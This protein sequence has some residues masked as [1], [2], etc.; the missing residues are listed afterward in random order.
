[1]SAVR[2]GDFELMRV[3][4]IERQSMPTAH[5]F[6]DL[7]RQMLQGYLRELGP[8]MIDSDTLELVM[9]FH[10]WVLRRRDTVLLVDCCVGDDK[11]RPTRPKWHRRKSDFLERLAGLGVNPEDV[12]AVMCTHL[13]VDHVGWNT[14]LID[15]RW[16]PTFP[17]ARYIMAEVEYRH[18]RGRADRE[19][20]SLNQ[21][22]FA[23]SVLPVVDSG[24]AELVP[25]NHRI[26]EGVHFEPA[27][28]HTPGTVLVHVEDSGQHGV[29]TGD[30]MHHPFQLDCPGMLS[31]YCEDPA[32]SAKSRMKLCEDYADTSTRILTAHFPNPSSGFIRRDGKRYRFQ[33]DPK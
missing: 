15:G 4:D 12:N 20:N 30:I 21:G 6:P 2:I 1:M 13:H 8:T 5:G 17:N 31:G 11:E 26:A 19:G 22:S 33:F 24:Q 27:P 3:A 23:D 32:A 18:W 14:R 7:T 25:M 10:T 9:S 16:V 29:C 28:G